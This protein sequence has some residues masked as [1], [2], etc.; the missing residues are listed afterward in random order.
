MCRIPDFGQSWRLL[1]VLLGT[2]RRRAVSD[3]ISAFA[4]HSGRWILKQRPS[5][6][7]ETVTRRSDVLIERWQDGSS[8]NTCD[9]VF[10]F[11]NGIPQY[12]MQRVRHRATHRLFDRRNKG[13]GILSVRVSDD[14]LNGSAP[15]DGTV[16]R[17]CEVDSGYSGYSTA[18]E[19]SR[20][21]AKRSDVGTE[22]PSSPSARWRDASKDLRLDQCCADSLLQ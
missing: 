6:R 8:P 21:G 18:D 17:E 19:T 5:G 7:G 3:N 4:I 9:G 20:L 11:V 12:Q 1:P 13:A 10:D 22:N 16:V 15:R 2:R 14:V